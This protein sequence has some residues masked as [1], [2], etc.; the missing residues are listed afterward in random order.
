[1]VVG[2]YGG[3]FNPP[4][5]GHALV[6]G[7]LGW[8]GR[9]DRVWLVPAFRHAFAKPLAPWEVRLAACRA[10]A[11]AV[12]PFVSVEPIEAELPTPS[13]TIHTLDALAARHP[14]H[15]LRLV[16]GADVR[17]QRQQW[18]DWDRIAA[19]Y[20]PI[21]VG[22]AGYPPVEDAPTFPAVSSTE[23]RARM[24]RGESVDA[25]VPAGVRAVWRAAGLVQS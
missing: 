3:S 13:Y 7:W 24:A 14:G 15:Q 11:A 23:V 4:H 19:E 10:L 25:W 16:V 21:V 17:D 6:A 12:G 22:R 5:V 2:V 1:M 9:V 8:T 20:P 18:R